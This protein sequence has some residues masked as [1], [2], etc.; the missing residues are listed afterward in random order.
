MVEPAAERGDAVARQPAVG[1]DL[2][3]ARAP[4]ADAADA[5]ARAEALEMRPQAAHAGH[6]VLELGELDLELALGRVGVAGEDVEDHRGAVEHRQVELGLEVALLA[7]VSS[8]SATTVGVRRLQQR[9]ELVDLARPQVEVGVRLVA[10]LHDLRRRRP[11]P[12]CAAAR[13]APR[14]RRG[15]GVAAIMKARCFAAPR[16]LGRC[17]AGL[18]LAAVAGLL[19][20]TPV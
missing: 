19:H 11:R 12:R 7:G 13:A 6:V 2:G 8:S 4:G 15:S 5:A 1:L 17:V 9:L 20:R 3:L 18:G 14:A 10:E 16:A